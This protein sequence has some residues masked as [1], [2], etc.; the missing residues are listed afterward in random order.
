MRHYLICAKEN[1][2]AI[3]VSDEVNRFVCRHGFSK[4]RIQTIPNGIDTSRI[5]PSSKHVKNEPF[6]F[7]AF[8][9]RNVQKRVDVILKAV[10]YIKTDKPYEVWITEGTDTRF[11]YEENPDVHVKLIPQTSD[12]NSLFSKVDCFISSSISET[13]S[14][15]IAE[16]AYFGLPVI[17]SRIEGTKWN[18]DNPGS[19][20]FESLNSVDLATQM[21]SVLNLSQDELV[22]K[23]RASTDYI[24]SRYT[25]DSWCTQVIDFFQKHKLIS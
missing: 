9:G 19:Y 17:Q 16:S 7:L 3:A 11:I 12:I 22:K 6:I 1:V 8:G 15:A 25:L 4:T 18:E 2:F 21:K 24:A 14:Y 5:T 10:K 13:F 20:T 23:G